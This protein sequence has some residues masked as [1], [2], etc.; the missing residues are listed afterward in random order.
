MQFLKV[1]CVLALS[2]FYATCDSKVV[3]SAPAATDV[4][5]ISDMI[6]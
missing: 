3:G 4:S 1:V 2:G 5:Q 6:D